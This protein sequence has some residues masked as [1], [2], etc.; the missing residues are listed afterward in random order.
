MRVTLC[1]FVS[2]GQTTTWVRRESEL[3]AAKLTA[4][5][6]NALE[7]DSA[8]PDLAAC[9]VANEWGARYDTHCAHGEDVGGVHGE[10]L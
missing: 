4:A 9:F 8:M 2:L 3:A 10:E 5:E 7:E 6:K 1:L